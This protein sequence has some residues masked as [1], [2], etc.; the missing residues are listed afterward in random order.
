[1]AENIMANFAAYP[2]SYQIEQT[3]GHIQ[4]FW[5]PVMRQQLKQD[6]AQGDLACSELMELIIQQI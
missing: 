1:M 2:K 3:I 6:Y 5:T 4:Q